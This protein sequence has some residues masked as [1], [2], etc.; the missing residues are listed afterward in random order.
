MICTI[1][2]N[3]ILIWS[4]WMKPYLFHVGGGFGASEYDVYVGY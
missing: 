1:Y 3:E 4:D 2:P